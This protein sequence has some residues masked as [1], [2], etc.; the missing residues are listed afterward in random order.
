MQNARAPR[1]KTP[2][3][4]TNENSAVGDD[5]VH[6]MNTRLGLRGAVY[7]CLRDGPAEV[8]TP[9]ALSMGRLTFASFLL[10]Q[11][12]QKLRLR[13]P[14]Y[15]IQYLWRPTL[16]S[17]TARCVI[18]VA[19]PAPCQCFSPGRNH[20]PLVG[21]D[22]LGHAAAERRLFHGKVEARR[23]DADQCQPTTSPGRTSRTLP[24]QLCTRPVPWRIA[25]PC[26]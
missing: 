11:V 21:W 14:V 25:T 23:A 2:E 8:T 26:R 19:G 16:T 3:S 4:S 10:A 6:S 18:I 17:V 5:L 1:T 13:R 7:R 12:A 15:R 22:L 20:E 24:P 9:S